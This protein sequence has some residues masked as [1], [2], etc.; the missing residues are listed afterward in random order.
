MKFSRGMQ[1][2]PGDGKSTWWFVFR[3]DELLVESRNEAALVPRMPDPG[4]LGMTLQRRQYLGMLEGE[5]V[6]S[7]E[8]ASEAPPPGGLGFSG[9]RGLFGM[10]SEDVFHLAGFAYQVMDWDRTHLYCG[11]CGEQ[12]V[13]KE[14]ERAKVCPRCGLLSYPRISPAIIVAVV[15]DNRLLL[16]HAN[17][18]P[19]GRYSVIAGFVEPGESLEQCVQREVSEEVGIEVKGI[20]YFGSQSWPFPNSLM[21]AF[22]AEYAGGEIRVDRREISDAG[23]YSADK[24]PSIPG[25]VSIARRLIDWFVETR[26]K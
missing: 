16:G 3:G 26:A 13:T 19:S 6:Y 8:V 17:R 2:D 11:R 23:W 21:I 1:P 25:K 12:N 22:T 18:F 4:L 7:G 15:R 9:L 5:S 14:D 24:L 10:L 20:R